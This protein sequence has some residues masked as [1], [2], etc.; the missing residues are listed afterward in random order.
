MAKADRSKDD[1]ASIDTVDEQV[2][3]DIN[4]D[5]AIL[6]ETISIDELTWQ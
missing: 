6:N 2:E 5:T 3:L 4:L 1:A